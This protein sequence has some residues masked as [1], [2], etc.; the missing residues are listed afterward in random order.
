[1][2]K[3]ICIN[4]SAVISVIL[5]DYNFH[6]YQWT[7]YSRNTQTQVIT[8]SRAFPS[9]VFGVPVNV[10]LYVEF[11]ASE[12]VVG[13]SLGGSAEDPVNSTEGTEDLLDN[14]DDDSDDTSDEESNND[15]P[16][17]LGSLECSLEDPLDH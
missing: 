7:K 15:P 5:G 10:E 6:L 12:D 11:A 9:Q 13:G 2:C 4:E 16:G 8:E 3:S 17:S 14:P 1:M